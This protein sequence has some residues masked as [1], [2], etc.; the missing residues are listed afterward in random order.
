MEQRERTTCTACG[1]RVAAGAE[2]CGRCH[3][4]LTSPEAAPPLHPD[5]YGGPALPRRFSRWRRSDVSFGPIGRIVASVL[6]CAVPIWWAAAS[7][8]VMLLMWV[9]VISPQLLRSIWKKTPIRN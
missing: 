4:P 2:W 6:L 3:A 8:L 7:S 5:A 9:F 1:S